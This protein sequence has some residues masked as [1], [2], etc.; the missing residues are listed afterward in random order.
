MIGFLSPHDLYSQDA[1]NLLSSHTGT[2]MSAI[3]TDMG[4]RD[5]ITYD[6]VFK[7]AKCY[8]D[9]HSLLV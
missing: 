4:G 2:L 9:Q 6:V 3:F 5:V 1:L 8:R 7:H